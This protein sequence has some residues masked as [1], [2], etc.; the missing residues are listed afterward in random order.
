MLHTD[1]L[2]RVSRRSL[3]WALRIRS[4]NIAK[5]F[6]IF[7]SMRDDKQMM[8]LDATIVWATAAGHHTLYIGSTHYPIR[9]STHRVA[10][11]LHGT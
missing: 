11:L 10:S 7:I 5:L 4:A 2:P 1:V 3:H 8:R 9:I 6:V